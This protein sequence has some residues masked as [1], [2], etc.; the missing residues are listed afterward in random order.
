MGSRERVVFIGAGHVAT[1][2]AQAMAR[3]GFDIEQVYSRTSDSAESLAK[4]IEAEA[5][6]SLDCVKTDADLYVISLRDNAL[7]ELLPQIV[8][9]KKESLIVHTSGSI[10][11]ALLDKYEG[12]FGV[13]Y[14]M[15]TFSKNKEVD[16]S[17]VHL[18]IEANNAQDERYLLDRF[19]TLS[20]E[21]HRAN[22][23]QRQKLHL[24]AVFV[25]NFT[26]HMYTLAAD[27][28]DQYDLPFEAMHTLIKET[29]EKIALLTPQEAQTGPAVRQDTD[30]INRHL[31]MLACRP[32]TQDIY[33]KISN[34]IIKYKSK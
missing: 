9:N 12:R 4:L 15:Q 26:N 31:A 32:D 25:C 11:L 23:E 6:T 28:L 27:L 16:L 19:S 3:K 22:S 30:V 8:A 5:V 18:F 2:L 10:P 7:L 29:T 21:V 24:A 13:V 1:H 33:R 14:P 20:Q 17:K 34:S